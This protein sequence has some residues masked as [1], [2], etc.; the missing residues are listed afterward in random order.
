M[1]R[2]I[3]VVEP[4]WLGV[5]ENIKC[6]LTNHPTLVTEVCEKQNILPDAKKASW[7]H[8]YDEIPQGYNERKKHLF[9]VNLLYFSSHKNMIMKN[10]VE[11]SY[12]IFPDRRLSKSLNAS[13]LFNAAN[14]WK[15]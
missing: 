1:I 14:L 15:K 2:K 6:I 3:P 5:L 13:T 10:K 12:L 11:I 4:F 7:Y 9:I 8:K